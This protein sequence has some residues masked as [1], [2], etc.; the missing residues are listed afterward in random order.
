M[1]RSWQQAQQAAEEWF[2]TA[3]TDSATARQILGIL[4]HYARTREAYDRERDFM[5][6]YGIPAAFLPD[7]EPGRFG[8]RTPVRRGNSQRPDAEITRRSTEVAG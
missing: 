6:G 8:A 4:T 7:P 5:I 2:Q 1:R 3:R